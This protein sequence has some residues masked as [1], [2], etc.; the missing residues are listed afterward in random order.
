MS[1]TK[2]EEKLETIKDINKIWSII[3][4]YLESKHFDVEII[5]K[6]IREYE[7]H[8]VP[9]YHQLDIKELIKYLNTGRTFQQARASYIPGGKIHSPVH[10]FAASQSRGIIKKHWKNYC[11]KSIKYYEIKGDHY[12][13]FKIPQV[14]EF[15]KTF[16]Q[17][18]ENL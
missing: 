17:T 15:A 13:I 18:I 11:K 8:V 3:I 7:A 2:L 4:D 1:D 5:K 9:D 10:Y 6:V 16:C 12:S 14:L